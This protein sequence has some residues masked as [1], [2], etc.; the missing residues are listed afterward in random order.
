MRPYTQ[1]V[2][3]NSDVSKAIKKIQEEGN[4]VEVQTQNVKDH[5]VA[6]LLGY[7]MKGE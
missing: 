5:L 6:L 4:Q 1:G 7:Q 2:E 3:F